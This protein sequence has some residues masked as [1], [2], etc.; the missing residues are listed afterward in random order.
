M[1][2]KSRFIF[3]FLLLIMLSTT[4]EAF[5]QHIIKGVVIDSISNEPLPFVSVFLKGTSTGT[6][7][8]NTGKFSLKLPHTNH[9]LR[10]TSIGYQEKTLK[11][12]GEKE[13][14]LSIRLS[15]TS[16]QMAEVVVRSKNFKYKKKNNPAVFFVKKVIDS[17]KITML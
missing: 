12:P 7:T 15:P 8:D 14:V 4:F 16:K 2:F 3:T 17:I 6:V 9:I 5:S 13:T 10:I 11:P 1:T